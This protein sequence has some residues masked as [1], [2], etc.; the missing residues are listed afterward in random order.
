MFKI[1][2]FDKYVGSREV[3]RIDFGNVDY[4]KYRDYVET[5]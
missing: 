4:K 1:Q 2:K 5:P 3:G